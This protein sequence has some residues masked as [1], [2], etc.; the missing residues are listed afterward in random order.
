MCSKPVV[1]IISGL[2]PSGGAGMTKDIVT[3]YQNGCHPLNIV[4]TLTVQNSIEFISAQPVDFNYLKE[5]MNL[6]EK[7]FPIKAVKIGLIPLEDEWIK[8]L[9]G[10]LDNFSC[11]IVI[12]PVLKATSQKKELVIPEKFF[13]LINGKNKIITPNFNELKAIF[14][15]FS[16]ITSDCTE[17]ISKAVSEQY[18]C[19]VVTTFEGKKDAVLIASEGYVSLHKIELI[20]TDREIHGT[21]CA[22]SSALTARLALGETIFSAVENASRFV[23][24]K[25]ND[26]YLYN[27]NGQYFF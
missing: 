16:N 5:S 25:I 1:L 8:K 18:G 3:V 7:E 19:T 26:R 4:S 10:L 27:K 11:P 22:F 12:D 14:K 17:T 13:D 21:G 2:D 15:N 23:T 9:S 24:S 6:L 20:K